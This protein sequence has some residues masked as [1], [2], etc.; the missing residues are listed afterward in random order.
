MKTITVATL[1]L[2]ACALQTPATAVRGDSLYVG[3]VLAAHY[4]HPV[5][6]PAHHLDTCKPYHH[7]YAPDG[8]LLTKGLDGMFEHHRGMFLG[9]NQITT[10]KDTFDVWHCRNQETMRHEGFALPEE[11]GLTGEW[12]VAKVTW[13]DGKDN[14]F[15]RELRAMRALSRAVGMTSFQI[16]IELRAEMPLHFGSDPQHSGHQFR[17]LQAFAEKD[18]PPAR[19]VRPATAKAEPEDVWTG[20]EWLAQVLPLPDGPVTIVRLEH[21]GNPSPV[22]S[23]TRPYG[24]FGTTFAFD[25]IPGKPLLLHYTYVVVIGELDKAQC[26]KLVATE[27]NAG[28]R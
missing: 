17:A 16:V 11:I 23:S 24:R 14:V 6:D 26:T 5:H 8:R 13:R 3:A 12:Q 18:A 21:A 4:E 2:T 22:I 7:I 9:W 15:V 27:Q 28:F 1:V 20:C 10:G 19:Y 25:L